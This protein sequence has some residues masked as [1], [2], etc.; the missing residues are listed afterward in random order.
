MP[1]KNNR[2]LLNLYTSLSK[3]SKHC[4][5]D[6]K[7]SKYTGNMSNFHPLKTKSPKILSGHFSG[8]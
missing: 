8:L 7:L 5:F 1:D 2:V 3:F 6:G 4:K